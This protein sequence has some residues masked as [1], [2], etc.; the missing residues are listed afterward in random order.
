VLSDGRFTHPARPPQF[1]KARHVS[2]LFRARRNGGH[3]LFFRLA[4]FARLPVC[5]LTCHAFLT[6]V[7]FF[8]GHAFLPNKKATQVWVASDF[9]KLELL[10]H[11][12]KRIQLLWHR[13]SCLCRFAFGFG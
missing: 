4:R 7:C 3:N 13:H 6:I 5:F 9:E 8:T 12:A 10:M 11:F 1:G 2:Q